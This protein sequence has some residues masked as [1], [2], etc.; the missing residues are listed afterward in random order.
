MRVSLPIRTLLPWPEP[1]T[2]PAAQPSLTMK[3]GLIFPS[4][5]RPRMPSVPK[6]LRIPLPSPPQLLAEALTSRR[7]GDLNN[8]SRGAATSWTRIR[9]APRSA[10]STAA[11]TLPA[12]RSPTSR[13]VIAPSMDLRDSPTKRGTPSSANCPSPANKA[14]LWPGSCRSQSRDPRPAAP[15]GMPAPQANR[16]PPSEKV[17][18]LSHH[19]AVDAAPPA[20]RRLT[21]HVHQADGDRQARGRRPGPRAGA[22]PDI[23]DHTGPAAHGRRHHLGLAGVD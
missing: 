9:L 7:P 21:A 20:W 1:R 4:P 12:R 3:S 19:V 17:G 5:T 2:R 16:D 10:A 13:P 14:R 8:I 18:D 22:G 23:V 6:Y 15:A 11:A